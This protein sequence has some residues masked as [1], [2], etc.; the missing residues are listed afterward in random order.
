MTR[1]Q[2]IQN[3]LWGLFAGDALAMPAHWFYK[4]DFSKFK[5]LP[6]WAFHNRDDP[7]VPLAAGREP[8]DAAKAADGSPKFTIHESGEHKMQLEK[9]LT[10]EVLDW[11]FSQSRDVPIH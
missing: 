6:V 1:E 3:A 7:V 10:P 11:L 4:Y 2:R 9:N 8:V 5:D